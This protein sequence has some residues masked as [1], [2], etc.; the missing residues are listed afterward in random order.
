MI[1]PESRTGVINKAFISD[2]FL[3]YIYFI[4]MYFENL[5]RFSRMIQ[6][7]K[8]FMLLLDHGQNGDLYECTKPIQKV[9]H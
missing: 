2:S 1:H 8:F 6:A 7:V 9:N 5:S 4:G 3:P